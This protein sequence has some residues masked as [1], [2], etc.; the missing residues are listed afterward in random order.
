MKR[1]PLRDILGLFTMSRVLLIMV[2][3]FGYILLTAP[4]YSSLPVDLAALFTTW[5]HWDAANYV[6]IAQ[7]GYQTQYDLAFFPLF[8]LLIS[9]IAYPFGSWGYVAAG[10]IISNL[11]L[12]AAMFV[13]YQL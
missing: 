9:A 4:K 2:T 11:A 8:P 13:I 12:L 7:Y 5:N 6:R 3:Y 10:M 1:P